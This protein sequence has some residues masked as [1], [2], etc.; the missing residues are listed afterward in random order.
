[1]HTEHLQNVRPG[2]VV[3]GWLVAAACVSLIFLALT[4]I[5]LSGDP[6]SGGAVAAVVSVAAGFAIGGFVTGFRAFHAPIL[7]GVAIGLASLIAWFALNVLEVAVFPAGGWNSLSPTL[8]AGLLV[9]QVV[10]AVFGAWIGYRTALQGQPEP[11]D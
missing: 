4:A 6:V 5:G 9:E 11:R 7:H 3:L 1:M 8:T 10:F 2:L